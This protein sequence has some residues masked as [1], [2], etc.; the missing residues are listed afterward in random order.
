MKNLYYAGARD[1]DNCHAD[2]FDFVVTREQR[3]HISCDGSI[4]Q[5]SQMI[6]HL[7]Y[8]LDCAHCGLPTKKS[9]RKIINEKERD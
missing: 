9:Q 7:S 8:K 3:V 6:D 4:K 2:E 1:C 5:S